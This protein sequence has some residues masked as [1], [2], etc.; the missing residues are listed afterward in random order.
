[1]KSTRAYS[2]NVFAA[3]LIAAVASPCTMAA[4]G[5]DAIVLLGPVKYTLM[6][7]PPPQRSGGIDAN[8]GIPAWMQ[9]RMSRY[10]AKA[11]SATADDG[12]IFTDSDVVTSVEADGLRKTCVQEVASNTGNGEMGTRY[13]PNKQEQIVV[14]RGDL[15][16]VCR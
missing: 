15:V 4:P 12:T 10:T 5:E 9:A 2:T 6:P 8:Q 7:G 3:L 16:N 14:L 1:M 13:G 11:F